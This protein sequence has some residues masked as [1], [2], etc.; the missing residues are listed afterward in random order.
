M[1]KVVRTFTELLYE[2]ALIVKNVNATNGDELNNASTR[3]TI[4]DTKNI[5]DREYILDYED[6][7]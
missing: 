5:D 6:D 7:T 2:D 1:C 3:M 4:V